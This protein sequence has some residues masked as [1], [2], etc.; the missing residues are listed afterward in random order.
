M[1]EAYEVIERNYDAVIVGAGGAGLRAAL[2]M[3]SSGLTTACVTKVFPT[4]SHT[5]VAQGGMAPRS[6][7]CMTETIGVSTCTTR[8][9]APTGSVIR[10]RSSICAGRLCPRCWNL[11]ITAFL[12]HAPKR[13]RCQI[14]S[15]CDPFRVQK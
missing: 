10:T 4:R 7:I 5:V 6:A 2:G 15:K 9:R 8:S 14:A 12:A 3:A 13:A 11:N 1:T